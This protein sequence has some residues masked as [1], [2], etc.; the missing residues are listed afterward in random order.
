MN[1]LVIAEKPSVALRLALSLAEDKPKRHFDN[2]VSYFELSNKQD[3]L[4]VVAAV[5]HLFTVTQAEK[6]QSLP[7]FSIEWQPL[8][9][10]E[11]RAYFTKKYLDIISAVGKGCDVLINACDYD[12]E[13]SVIGTNIISYLLYGDP[14]KGI[15][16]DESLEKIRRMHFSTTTKQDL[17]KAYENLEPFDYGNFEAGATRH[18]LDWL[19][20]INL[21]R[22]LMRALSKAGKYR[23]LSIGRV[24]GPALA[25]L[26]RREEEIESFVPKDFW[27]V[28]IVAKGKEFVNVK[29]RIFDKQLAEGIAERAKA[30]GKAV[31]YSVESEKKKVF[32]LPPF[33]LT[34]LQVTASAV[35]GFDPSRTL[36]IAQSLY[37]RSYISYPRTSSQKLPFTL[38][39]PRIISELSKQ[40]AYKDLANELISKHRFV[41]VEGKKEDEAHPAIFPT[42]ER[43]SKLSKEEEKLYDLIVRRFLSVFAEPATV[44]K[45]T[46]MLKIEEEAYVAEGMKVVDPGW[47][48]YYR[49]YSIKESTMPDF[50]QGEIVKIDKVFEKKDTTKPPERYTK[51]M[52]IQVLESKNLGTKA[53]RAEIVDTLFRRGYVRGSR[54]QV[55][56][57]GRTVYKALSMYAPEI[58]DENLTRKLE[59]DMDGLVH[60]R[61]TREQVIEEGKEIIARALSKFSTHEKEIGSALL[62]GVAESEKPVVLGKCPNCGGDLLLRH[63]QSG[64]NYAI[65]SNWPK[66]KTSYPLPANATIVPTGKVCEICHTPI[67]KVFMRG[68][69]FTMDL[70]PNCPSKAGWKK[71]KKE[72]AKGQA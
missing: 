60:G 33:D 24:Q 16:K 44:E 61:T 48:S 27:S 54:M 2:G 8:Y 59:E 5:G 11:K 31:V 42:G 12:I 17:L 43:P 58:V 46:V 47:L 19:W 53:T 7:V 45:K 65:C 28:G 64:K 35:L 23:T 66:C 26:V 30:A 56:P 3:R 63:S 69:V 18:I 37:E 10:V 6:G 14:N 50:K 29:G 51:A 25:I 41:P 62:G 49:F 38:N 57:L 1:K 68:K 70:D 72:K 71:K 32:P 39:L 15:G 55:T 40:E 9:K 52:L 21:S 22:A 13:G 67:V 4:F 36:E 20:G 34:D